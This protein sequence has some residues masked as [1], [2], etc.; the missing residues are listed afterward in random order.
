MASCII[1]R[2]Q[3]KILEQLSKSEFGFITNP[4]DNI[5]HARVLAI[6][7][8]VEVSGSRPE[9]IQLAYSGRKTLKSLN[10][11]NYEIRSIAA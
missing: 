3:A 7:S 5:E 10:S 9:Q 4:S 2:E 8:L 11:S 1:P 6:W